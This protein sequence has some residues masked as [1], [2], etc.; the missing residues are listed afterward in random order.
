LKYSNLKD[1]AIMDLMTPDNIKHGL[2]TRV[3]GKEIIYYT[4]TT[5]TNDMAIQ[6]AENGA[7][8]G[9]LIVAEEQTSGKGRRGR[10]W[11]SPERSSILASLILHPDVDI[12]KAGIITMISGIAITKSIRDLVQLPAFI[13]WS[14]DVVINNRK[15]SGILVEA[16]IEKKI[17]FVV[18]GIGVNVN[19]SKDQF[20]TEIR[21]IATSLSIESGRNLSRIYLLQEIL[22][23]FEYRYL[24][25]KDNDFSDEWKSLSNM[26]GSYI[27]IN[28]SDGMISGTAMDVDDTGALMIRLD[29]GQIRRIVSGEV[30]SQMIL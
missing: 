29:T 26:M 30:S 19:T 10:S 20:P 13:K 17:K 3:L 7:E 21:E 25:L 5:S 24:R 18:A 14:N 27:E 8:E 12:K 4:K 9:T 2:Y 6:L 15:V 16:K 11:L 1:R 23:Q 28:T 22:K